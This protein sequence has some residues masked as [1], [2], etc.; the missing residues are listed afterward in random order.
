MA[1]IRIVLMQMER[2]GPQC[3]EAEAAGLGKRLNRGV[4]LRKE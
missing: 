1:W 3:E 4:Q 2:G